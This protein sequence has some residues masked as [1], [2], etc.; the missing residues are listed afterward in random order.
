[1]Y[2]KGGGRGEGEDIFNGKGGSSGQ[3]VGLSKNSVWCRGILKKFAP[4]KNILCSPCST[5]YEYSLVLKN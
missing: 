5:H 3:E 4:F 2:T 1:M